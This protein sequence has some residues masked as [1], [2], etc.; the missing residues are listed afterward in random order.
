[1]GQG[2]PSLNAT[3]PDEDYIRLDNQVALFFAI[4]LSSRAE[5][6]TLMTLAAQ[7]LGAPGAH[8]LFVAHLPRP[9]API[10]EIGVGGK[11]MAPQRLEKIDSET[12]N[13]AGGLGPARYFSTRAQPCRPRRSWGR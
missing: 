10:A 4:T 9:F 3:W 13:G 6:R 7:A 2:V 8:S 1:M 12:G 5:A 11:E